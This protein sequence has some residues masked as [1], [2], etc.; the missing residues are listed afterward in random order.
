MRI[1]KNRISARIW[2][3]PRGREVARFLRD[4]REQ[5]YTKD[6]CEAIAT[7]KRNYT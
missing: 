6:D 2:P 4:H 1:D 3:P 7:E 5:D